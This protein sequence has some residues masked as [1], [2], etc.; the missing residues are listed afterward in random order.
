MS[1]T[2]GP[3]HGT[4]LVDFF[5]SSCYIVVISRLR[6]R[7]ALVLR[8]GAGARS[9]SVRTPVKSVNSRRDAALGGRHPRDCRRFWTLVSGTFWHIRGWSRG[10]RGPEKMSCEKRSSKKVVRLV[11]K[12]CRE[13]GTVNVFERLCSWVVCAAQRHSGLLAPI[14]FFFCLFFTRKSLWLAV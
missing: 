13:R 2:G 14:R 4:L 3:E 12:R 6:S 11:L 5:A 1:L 8:V 10:K 7:R 9:A